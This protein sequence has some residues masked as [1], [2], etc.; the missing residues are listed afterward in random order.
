MKIK[1][2]LHQQYHFAEWDPIARELKEPPHR[3][4]IPL[5]GRASASRHQVGVEVVVA[6]AV[7]VNRVEG[8]EE[9]EEVAEAPMIEEVEEEEEGTM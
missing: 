8:G 7:V 2:G 1:V 9:V 4:L 6:V 3:Q 5:Q